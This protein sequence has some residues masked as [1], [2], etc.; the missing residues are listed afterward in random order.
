VKQFG[1]E[2]K[3]PRSNRGPKAGLTLRAHRKNASRHLATDSKIREI[4]ERGLPL[5][6]AAKLA[7]LA[8]TNYRN[9]AQKL[10]YDVKPGRSGRPRLYHGCRIRGCTA[11]HYSNRMCLAHFNKLY[12]RQNA[13]KF[14][15]RAKK[16]R[17]A[18]RQQVSREEL[19]RLRSPENRSESLGFGPDKKIVHLACGWIGDDLTHHIRHCPIKPE[20][21]SA[22]S[23]YWGFDPSRP[24]VSPKQRET[25]SETQRMNWASFERRSNMARNRWGKGT[26]PR[27]Q[28]RKTSNRKILEIVASNPGLLLSEG[29]ALAGL[30]RIGFY[31]RVNKLGDF[32]SLVPAPRPQR[33]F[34]RL[35]SNA[36]LRRWIASQP[37]EFS[38]EQFM[39]FCVDN[40]DH[41]PLIPSQFASFI[42]HLETELRERAE[43]IAKIAGEIEGHKPAQ[44][45]MRLGNCVFERACA[46]LK[47]PNAQ[48]SKPTV[49]GIRGKS[50]RKPG[51]TEDRLREAR[52]LLAAIERLGGKRGAIKKAAGE[53][54]PTIDSALRYDRAR[55]TLRDYHR[56][57]QNREKN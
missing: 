48:L 56:L 29:A 2:S 53:V 4:A 39:Q 9:R 51:M 57:T 42:L 52:Q 49:A 30:S 25:Y 38:A 11:P 19:E 54:Y 8:R 1:A 20:G 36:E 14:K 37:Q 3:T 35:A 22:Y 7:G 21:W 23:R 44:S 16:Q 34:V 46:G 50:G 40:L 10:G 26:A 17:E 33:E 47:G 15:E 12:Y 41:G 31:K 13:D 24:P 27:L 28:T 6:E 18:R 43:W 55:Q 45:A 32:R 5:P